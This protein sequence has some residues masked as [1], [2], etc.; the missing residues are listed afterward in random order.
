[1]FNQIDRISL[2][3][4]ILSRRGDTKKILSRFSGSD[5]KIFTEDRIIKLYQ[6]AIS[7][8]SRKYHIPGLFFSYFDTLNK[9]KEMNEMFKSSHYTEIDVL[10]GVLFGIERT[11]FD[12]EDK[13]KIEELLEKY[14][15]VEES[16]VE[17]MI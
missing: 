10:E 7:D 17:E 9:Y 12:D 6:K 3:M 2:L 14:V 5:E 4:W 16:K 13:A 15:N 11:A 8:I 1:M